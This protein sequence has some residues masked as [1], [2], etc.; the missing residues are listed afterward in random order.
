M[1]TWRR[2]VRG[3]GGAGRLRALAGVRAGRSLFALVL[4]RAPFI[5]QLPGRSGGGIEAGHEGDALLQALQPLLLERRFRLDLGK[6]KNVKAEDLLPPSA[7]SQ[8]RQRG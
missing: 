3:P 1:C 6:K 8:Q 2:Q 4:A 7:E 5:L